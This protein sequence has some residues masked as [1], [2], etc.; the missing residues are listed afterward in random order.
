MLTRA[1]R[2]SFQYDQ[3]VFRWTILRYHLILEGYTKGKQTP[4][5]ES[6]EMQRGQV[7]SV[8]RND[9][10]NYLTFQTLSDLINYEVP[11]RTEADHLVR[12]QA[13]IVLPSVGFSIPLAAAATFVEISLVLLAIYFWL[14]YREARRSD[15]YPAS[16]TLFG[17]F[18]RTTLSRSVFALLLL[19]PPSAAVLLAWRSFWNTPGN[20]VPAILVVL[21]GHLIAREGVPK[22]K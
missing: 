7:P 13:S 11:N 21:I 18:A 6:K 16:A 2:Y 9:L 22:A 10:V 15:Q 12:E 19:L 20:I 17:V 8:S 14:F 3:S 4:L 5:G 1:R